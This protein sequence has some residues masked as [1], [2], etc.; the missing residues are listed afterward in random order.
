MQDRSNTYWK[1]I[2]IVIVVGLIIIFNEGIISEYKLVNKH[3]FTIATT[4]GYGGGGFVDFEFTVNGTVYKRAD[5][6]LQ[7]VTNGRKYFVKFYVDDPSLIAKIV[8]NEE[9]PEC[10]G[11]PPANGWSELP[12]CTN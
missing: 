2:G 3:R 1:W 4:K 8:S 12:K 6:G 11:E 5:K 9:V 10:V 7:L